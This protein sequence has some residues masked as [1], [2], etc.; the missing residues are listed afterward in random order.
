MAM[1]M[2][3]VKKREMATATT[4]VGNEEGDG[5]GGKSNGRKKFGTRIFG[6]SRAKRIDVIC[7][8]RYEICKG[9]RR[10]CPA[11]RAGFEIDVL[12]IDLKTPSPD[13][14]SGFPMCFLYVYFVV[15]RDAN[16]WESCFE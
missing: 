15:A 1:A 13:P 11:G 3:T 4:V 9:I 5:Y 10:E 12:I 6:S 14:G 7:K 8:V 16:Q 2:V